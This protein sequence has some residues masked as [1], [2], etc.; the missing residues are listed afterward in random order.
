MPTDPPDPRR[1][2]GRF[3]YDGLER[4]IHEKARL[5]ILASLASYPDGLL[6]TELKSLCALTDGNLSRQIQSLQESG[7]VEVWKRVSSQRP[8]TICRLTA[9]GR[10]RFLEYIAELERV[11]SDAHLKDASR[12]APLARTTPPSKRISP[13]I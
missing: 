7:L 6:F 8:Q 12:K 9:P 11:V 1:N 3:A 2:S 13:A 5:S 10:Q 4:V